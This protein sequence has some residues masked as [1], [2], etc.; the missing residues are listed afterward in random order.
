MRLADRSR[1]P[2]AAVPWSGSSTAAPRSTTTPAPLWIAVI[3]GV[4]V[5]LSIRLYQRT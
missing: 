1:T 4:F 2:D 3:F 5:P